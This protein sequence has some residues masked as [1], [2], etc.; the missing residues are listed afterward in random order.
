M[1]VKQ[2]RKQLS[3]ALYP[4]EEMTMYGFITHMEPYIKQ[5]LI[6]PRKAQV[7]EY[8][9]AQGIDNHR[10]LELL[11]K[12][13][14]EGITILQ[15]TEKIKR[16]EESGKDKFHIKYM[17]PRKD[18]MKNMRNL[19]INT[20]E[21]HIVEGCPLNEM[22]ANELD[23]SVT[24]K[25]LDGGKITY[26]F[27]KN[28]WGL[29]DELIKVGKD[30][31]KMSKE[32]NI[33]ID[34]VFIDSV[35][36]VYDITVT[37]K[38]LTEG[39][40]GTGILDNDIARDYQDTFGDRAIQML[41]NDIKQSDD[42]DNT[43]GRLGVLIDFLKKYKDEEVVFGDIYT[44]AIDFCKNELKKLYQNDDWVNTWDN[45]KE[46]KNTLKKMYNDLSDIKYKKDIMPVK[47]EQ[48]VTEE[49]E[50]ATSADASG[51]FSQPL[52][53]KPIRRKTVYLTQEQVDR[54][55]EEV[56][57]DT[58]IGNFGY[59]APALKRK[60]DPAYNHKNM[61]KDGMKNV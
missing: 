4:K 17:L 1:K 10:A 18:Y 41:V 25:T 39:A 14:D 19:Y 11:I 42:E 58:P 60:K 8:L 53:G 38:P 54:L 51:Q 43:W 48:I 37:T 22:N 31:K 59:D 3:E 35:D 28:G 9:I 57:M 56:V 40:W 44:N 61:F 23:S 33:Y 30:I 2:H 49:G 12:P 6:D 36:D 7:D 29:S 52:F 27:G 5:L 26:S 21:S 50:G 46:I 45:I 55:K 32:N 20:F 13:N 16:D 34:D 47:D 15:R 24:K